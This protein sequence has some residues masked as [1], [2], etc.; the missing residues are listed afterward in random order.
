MQTELVTGSLKLFYR[1]A[2]PADDPRAITVSV[3]DLRIHPEEP[4]ET[5]WRARR[6]F[7]AWS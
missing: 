5:H 4:T 3:L 1:A 6:F 2:I 7:Q